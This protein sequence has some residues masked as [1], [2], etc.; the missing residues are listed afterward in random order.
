MLQK[1]SSPASNRGSSSHTGKQAESPA[2]A[3]QLQP[4]IQDQCDE[5]V[6]SM[7]AMLREHLQRIGE[8]SMDLDGAKLVEQA[9]LI[10]GLSTLILMLSRLQSAETGGTV[11][12]RHH[13]NL[14]R[15][16]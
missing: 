11:C 7:A 6:R 8:P 14:A 16:N 12:C 15:T 2:R 4:F 9:L 10:G 5:A 1:D 3:K 13:C